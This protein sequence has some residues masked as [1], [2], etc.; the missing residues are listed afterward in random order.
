[1]KE[2]WS[3]VPLRQNNIEWFVN[4]GDMVKKAVGSFPS[5]YQAIYKRS[6]GEDTI[7][8]C[9]SEIFYVPRQ[10]TGDF[11]NLVKII[12]NLDIH[13]TVA[14]P[15]LF[16]AMDLPSNFEPRALA[17]LVYRTNL[18]SNTTFSTIYTAEAHAV[19]PMKVQN[20]V[21]FVN[22]IRVMASGDPFL[23]ELI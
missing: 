16:L 21:D 4:Q 23:M 5:H 9:S 15:M 11:S 22:L 14:V 17:N 6:V 13:H 19:Y 8:H 7:I 20:E 1:M 10:H 18:P 12:G 2:S 3:D